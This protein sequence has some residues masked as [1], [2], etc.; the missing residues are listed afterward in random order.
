MGCLNQVFFFLLKI[1]IIDTGVGESVKGFVD[2]LELI[3]LF[4]SFPRED[5]QSWSVRMIPCPPPLPE[6]R[7]RRE[8]LNICEWWIFDMPSLCAAV[9]FCLCCS[10]MCVRLTVSIGAVRIDHRAA[11]GDKIHLL[12]S[13][14]IL[15]R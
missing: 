2:R 7:S 5:V 3:P 13:S 1:D 4:C 9:F 12:Y 6:G 15:R 8:Y 14:C 11:T 10:S